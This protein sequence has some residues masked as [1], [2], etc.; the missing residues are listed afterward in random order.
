[1]NRHEMRL[2]PAPFEKIRAGR[3][4]IELRLYDEKR[5]QITVGDTIR[6]VNTD[7]PA[8]VLETVVEK[9]FL[10]DSFAELYSHLPLTA[11]GYAE[12]ELETASP[13]DMEA[14][15]SKEEQSRFGV[16]GIQITL[17]EG[18]DCE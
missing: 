16:V 3:K 1:M 14:Y 2:R 9:I 17:M 11:C 12:D 4:T 13:A 15:Y 8:E 6:F 7:E 5:Q 18:K 10:F